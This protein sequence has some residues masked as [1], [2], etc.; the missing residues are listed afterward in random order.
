LLHIGL[1]HNNIKNIPLNRNSLDSNSP[2]VEKLV[3]FA[4]DSKQITIPQIPFKPMKFNSVFLP[5]ANW[6]PDSIQSIDLSWNELF[7]LEQV[8]SVISMFPNIRILCLIVN[9]V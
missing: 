7:D 3:E 1:S 6:L 9:F 4:A 5:I 2:D 8:I